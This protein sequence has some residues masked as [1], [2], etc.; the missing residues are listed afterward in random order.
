V[1]CATGR[2]FLA[3]ARTAVHQIRRV[4]SEMPVCVFTDDPDAALNLDRAEVRAI[5]EPRYNN[6]DKFHALKKSPF[7]RTLYLDTDVHVRGGL[8]TLFELLAR[9]D[10]AGCYDTNRFQYPEYELALGSAAEPQLNGGVLALA[11]AP[12]FARA[13]E[14]EYD[15][16]VGWLDT[17]V[18][19]GSRLYW[20]QVALRAAVLRHGFR[21]H[22]LPPE[23]NMRPNQMVSLPPQIVHNRAFTRLT[24]AKKDAVLAALDNGEVRG[25]RGFHA[26]LLLW[27][28]RGTVARALWS[29]LRRGYV[30]IR[31]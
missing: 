17:N 22:V 26:R 25:T 30:A 7:D 15:Q 31:L 16:F 24:K 10:V 8:E 23:Y 18:A 11:D 1:I 13:W 19:A 4:Y 2:K 29:L 9:F 14:N 12:A 20:D 21:L 28:G 3:E 5:Q 27:R 6:S